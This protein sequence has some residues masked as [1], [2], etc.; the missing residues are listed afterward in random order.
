MEY[1]D[2]PNENAHLFLL[3][4]RGL[5]MAVGL[6]GLLL[7]V[8]DVHARGWYLVFSMACA[9]EVWPT[10]RRGNN[11]LRTRSSTVRWDGAWVR[12]LRPLARWLSSEEA[13]I[14]SFCAWNNR[15][16]EEAFSD[17]RARKAL[18]LL[19][20]CVQAA[21]CKADIIEEPGN[22]YHCGLCPMGEFLEEA[23]SKGWHCRITN[24]SH[25]AYRETREFRP[26]LIVA[27]ACTD[28]ILKGL[29][30]LPEVPSYVVPLR[31]PHGMCVDTT[32][33]VPV[34][35]TAMDRLVEPRG[36]RQAWIQPLKRDE[37][38]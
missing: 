33:S 21:R 27:V 19:P 26:D 24:R 10:F 31:L 35:T 30:K 3:A 11:Y 6:V 18:V 29:L 20:H 36:D 9:A 25:K 4:R 16:I 38:A 23:L 32:F 17:H 22:C 12:V 5:P 13:W 1:P 7:A 37:I 28:R 8:L 15:R 34:L 2:I 14:L